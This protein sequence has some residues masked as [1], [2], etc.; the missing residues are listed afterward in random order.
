MAAPTIRDRERA[1][2]LKDRMHIT[3]TFDL[4]ADSAAPFDRK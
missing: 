2:E 1:E 4:L 3:P